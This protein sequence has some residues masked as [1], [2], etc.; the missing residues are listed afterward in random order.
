VNASAICVLSIWNNIEDEDLPFALSTRKRIPC[1]IDIEFHSKRLADESVKAGCDLPSMQH[2]TNHSVPKS[3]PPKALQVHISEHHNK[4]MSAIFDV[5]TVMEK[6]AL[7]RMSALIMGPIYLLQI[8]GAFRY[9]NSMWFRA[10]GVYSSLTTMCMVFVTF[11]GSTISGVFNAPCFVV[12][13]TMFGACFFTGV[14]EM[15]RILQPKRATEQE[16]LAE[17]YTAVESRGHFMIG[18]VTVLAVWIYCLLRAS[19]HAFLPFYDFQCQVTLQ[20]LYLEL[21]SLLAAVLMLLAFMFAPANLG[22]EAIDFL[23][24]SE[25]TKE[26][27]VYCTLSLVSTFLWFYLS[28]WI[29][30]YVMIEWY[31]LIIYLHVGWGL[32]ILGGRSAFKAFKAERNSRTA[33][34]RRMSLAEMTD[35]LSEYMQG[36][37]K[38]AKLEA[39]L[40]QRNCIE[41]LHFVQELDVWIEIRKRSGS[42]RDDLNSML[43]KIFTRYCDL[44]S[45]ES[46]VPLSS[47]MYNDIEALLKKSQAGEIID[48]EV[49]RRARSYV[50][51]RML[52]NIFTGFMESQT[53]TER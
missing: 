41:Y 37:E 23:R 28:K 29:P 49:V 50:M 53:I 21:I 4:R 12:P 39:H 27:G 32:W 11:L 1:F 10:R 22:N 19:E 8:F 9:R 25:Q 17:G 46:P 35:T 52:L 24:Q 33:I 18:I 48:V 43:E 6:A 51:Q 26:V 47:E 2:A 36:G 16:V 15:L 30:G 45:S 40:K 3:T 5:D 44:K 34:V 7:F 13:L 42:S 14:L 20:M 31:V 38:Q